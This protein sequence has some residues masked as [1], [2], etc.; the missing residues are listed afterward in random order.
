M[1]AVNTF[2]QH[3]KH[4]SSLFFTKISRDFTIFFIKWISTHTSLV[5][6]DLGIP[7][8]SPSVWISTHT[9]LVGCDYL[10]GNADRYIYNFYSHIPCG[11]W[12]ED[13]RSHTALMEFLLTHPLW[14]VTPSFLPH[15][16]ALK[17][18]LT[19]P[20]WDVTATALNHLSRRVK[21]LLTHPLWDVTG[22]PE[23]M[24]ENGIFLLTHPLWDVT[25]SKIDAY[26]AVQFLLTHPLWDVTILLPVLIF[27][28]DYFYSHI[29]CGMWR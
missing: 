13:T 7:C 25:Q 17:F 1:K 15:Y 14:D 12:Q 4:F 2:L 8:L 6:C 21:F 28:L 20:L 5:G 10:L 26:D 29:P 24:E 19:H 3:F 18:L 9:S 16:H 11:M 22:T 27:F 23:P